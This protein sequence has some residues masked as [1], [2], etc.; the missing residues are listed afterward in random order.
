[1]QLT[2][3][4]LSL[5]QSRTASKRKSLQ[6]EPFWH[7]L[8]SPTLSTRSGTLLHFIN[9]SRSYSLLASFFGYAPSFLTVELTSRLVV[10]AAFPSASDEGSP[11]TQC[12]VQSS[13]SCLLMTSPRIYLGVP[14][15]TCM[16]TI[17]PSG[18]PPQTRSKHPLLSKPLL[19]C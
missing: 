15:S 8:T 3:F 6:T 17:W 9:S 13:S 5:N 16:L 7:L 18:P 4:L 11:R 2:K 19:M 12:L 1:M 14:M 10:F